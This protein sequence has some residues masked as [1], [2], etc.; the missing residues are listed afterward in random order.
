M[1]EQKHTA[2]VRQEAPALEVGRGWQ[3]GV[4]AHEGGVTL[5]LTHE[6]RAPLELEIS[7]TDAG[8]VVRARAARLEL[9]TAED[10]TAR[11]ESFHLAARGSVTIEGADITQSASGSL[12]AEAKD[13]SME[14]RCGDFKVLAND[15]VQLLGEE[16]LLNCEREAPAPSWLPPPPPQPIARQDTQGDPELLALL[17]EKTEG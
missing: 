6:E 1:S 17:E 9:E 3:L 13:I 15:D 14:A 2:L 4:V 5:A 10:I 11:C 7:I 8:P 16:V 12:R